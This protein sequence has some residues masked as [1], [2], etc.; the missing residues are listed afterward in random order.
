[1]EKAA[2][3]VALVMVLKTAPLVLSW[4]LI[5]LFVWQWR[6]IGPLATYFLLGCLVWLGMVGLFRFRAP[7]LKIHFGVSKPLTTMAVLIFAVA[8]YMARLRQQQLST[9]ALWGLPEISRRAGPGK[10]V[11]E[12]IYSKLRHPRYSEAGLGIASTALFS[13]Y[14]AVY[15]LLVVYIPIIF[16]VVIL[17]ERELKTRFGTDYEEYC[18]TVPRFIPRIRKILH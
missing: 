2:Y 16:F 3:I 7:L 18:K 15:I 11:T 8:V 13:N 12:G 4:I 17:E 1:M 14:L 5:H 10:L 6:R 9:S